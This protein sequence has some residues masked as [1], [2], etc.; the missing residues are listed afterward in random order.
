[1]AWLGAASDLGQGADDADHRPC[2]AAVAR[3]ADSAAAV[4]RPFPSWNRSMLTEISPMSRLFMSRNIEDGNGRAG[5][6][7]SGGAASISSRPARRGWTTQISVRRSAT[8]CTHYKPAPTACQRRW[9]TAGPSEP[10]MRE[11]ACAA[12]MA[13]MA[14]VLAQA[15]R[16]RLPSF[17][18]A[19]RASCRRCRRRCSTWCTTRS[20][21]TASHS[22]SSA[23]A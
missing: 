16:W 2:R 10:L 21:C 6:A 7:T 12:C 4:S 23:R 13:C 22:P 15:C 18:P 9:P 1:M 8:Q 17:A 20:R 19:R 11:A 3:G 5:T 14:L